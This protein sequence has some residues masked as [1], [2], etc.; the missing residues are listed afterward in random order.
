NAVNQKI[1]VRILERLGY[2][3]DVAGNGSE[4]VAAVLGTPYDLVLMDV[5]MPELDGLEATRQILRALPPQRRPR[6]VAMTANATA[7]DRQE[8]RAAGMDDYLPKPI[9]ISALIQALQRCRPALV[10]APA[11]RRRSRGP[12]TS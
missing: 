9:A 12:R 2:R 10:D 7:D 4:A 6:I 3:P 8:C 11:K 1:V 5:Q